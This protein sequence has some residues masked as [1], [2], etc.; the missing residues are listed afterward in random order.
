MKKSAFSIA[1]RDTV[2]VLTG[3]LFLGAGFGILMSENGFG[4]IWSAAM[5]VFVFAG[6]GQYLA[7]GLLASQAGLV[8]V[9]VAT[10]LVNARHIFYGIS[11]VDTYK[12][13][14]LKKYY[15]IFGLT[16]ETYSLV[17]QAKLGPGIDRSKYCFFVTLLDHFYWVCGCALG[18]ILGAT[19]PISFEGV[20]FVL[21]ALF[22]TLFVEQ[23][24]SSKNHLPALIGLGATTVCLL[25]FG[26]EYFL[27]PSMTLIATAL[28]LTREKARRSP[29]V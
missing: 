2:P 17:T 23:W 13:A 10:L 27:I 16:D 5:A 26:S 29:Y 12:H 21:T 7:V 3:Y 22:V 14:G 1:L 4:I 15:M 28:I 19:L 20:D 8:S 6:S 25:I 24:L 18:S 9:A 11:L